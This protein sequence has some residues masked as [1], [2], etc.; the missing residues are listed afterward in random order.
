MKNNQKPNTTNSET[1]ETTEKS[2]EAMNPEEYA[3]VGDTVTEDTDSNISEDKTEDELNGNNES[4]A[5]E[6]WENCEDE[7]STEKHIIEIKNLCNETD[8]ETV[9]RFVVTKRLQDY[10]QK[11]MGGILTAKKSSILI[12]GDHGTGKKTV[13]KYVAYCIA[14]KIAPPELCNYKTAIY[15]INTDT[16]SV[17][18]DLLSILEYAK[19]NGVE[20][21]MVYINDATRLTCNF[22]EQYESTIKKID[23]FGFRIFKFIF[24]F[25]DGVDMDENEA[26]GY[27]DFFKINAFSITVLPAKGISVITNVLRY[28]VEKLEKFHGVTI[29]KRILERLAMCYYARHYEECFDY[30][31]FINVIDTVLAQVRSKGKSVATSESIIDYYKRSFDIMSKLPKKYHK[32]TAIHESGHILL[33]LKI[34]KLYVVDGC[35]IMR[36]TDSSIEAITCLRKTFYCA[37]SED[38]VVNVVAMILAGRAAEFEILE[39]KR[40][41][42]HGLHKCKSFNRGASDDLETATRELRAW[43]MNNGAYVCTGINI[44]EGNYAELSDAKKKKVDRIVNKLMK[45]AYQHARATIRN[46]SKFILQMSNFLLKNYVATPNDISLI[47]RNTIKK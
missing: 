38:D 23:S 15:E 40:Y 35:S 4:E 18:S 16:F 37:Y 45:K 41:I 7:N 3:D 10:A 20:N 26:M 21:V 14:N 25:H 5:S 33:A 42:Q 31:L 12:A 27:V 32:I 30:T 28:E 36:E 2:R 43:V 24:I 47:A 39:E 11:V 1:L 44:Y 6:E 9:P 8:E 46:N 13:V 17:I 29:S 19:L 34:P 22:F